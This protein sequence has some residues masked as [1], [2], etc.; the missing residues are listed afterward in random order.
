MAATSV[1][2]VRRIVEGIGGG[3]SLQR[4]EEIHRFVKEHRFERCLE[5]GFAFG[6]S[7][8]WIG[9]ALEWNGFGTLTSVDLQTAH[10]RRPTAEE[11]VGR[12]GL[13]ERVELVYEETSYTWY[14]QRLLRQQLHDGQIEPVFDFVFLDGAHTWDVD[15]FALLLVDRL[16]KPGGW[17]LL[18][19]LD[20]RL[21]V[22]RYPDVPDAERKLAQVREIWDL[23]LMPDSSY[24]EMSTDGLWGW[25]R[26]SLTP[27]PSVRTVVRR[28]LIGSV[29]GLGRFI[30]SKLRS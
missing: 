8:V 26:K 9:S 4:G 12:A 13:A 19:D 16:L 2:D 14:L 27:T 29:R 6:V 21:D 30:G 17:I 28:D 18:D 3:T 22:E 15:G 24:D 10:E 5:L 7:S 20:W 1:G 11:I 25:A 23:L